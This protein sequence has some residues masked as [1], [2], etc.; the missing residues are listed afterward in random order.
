MIGETLVVGGKKWVAKKALDLGWNAIVDWFKKPSPT[1]ILIIGPG[2]VGKTTLGQ[3]LSLNSDDAP[4]D[5]KYVE[6]ISVERFPLKDDKN[7][8]IVVP[9]GQSHRIESTWTEILT[10][11]RDGKYRGVI[12]VQAYGHHAIGDFD[13]TNH[14]LYDAKKGDA[15]FL[16]DY[17]AE[18]RHLEE[19]VFVQLC[20]AIQKTNKP[21]WLLTLITKEDLWW[22]QRG[23]VERYYG[24]GKYAKI[25]QRCV[26]GKDV[27][28]FRHETASVSLILHNL[29]TE[30]NQ[31][32][33]TTV[34]GYDQP[35]QSESINKLEHIFKGL[36]DWEKKDA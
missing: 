32:L 26:R 20:D 7:V 14:K 29:T 16:K 22:D 19:S 13:Y 24:S 23:E 11:L 35:L 2:G 10:E 6:S 3:F 9:P 25:M 31:I 8:E 12:L 27:R 5:G 1:K 28:Q 17:L 21:L 18:C 34:A 33:K 36:M 4:E 15:E 30:R